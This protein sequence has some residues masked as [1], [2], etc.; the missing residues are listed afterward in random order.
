MSQLVSLLISIILFFE[1]VPLAG[2]PTLTVDAGDINGEV[3]TKATGFLYGIAQDGVPSAAMLNSL[4]ISSVSQKVVDGLQHPSGDIDDIYNQVNDC[5]YVVIYL[6]DAYDTWYYCYDEIMEKRKNGTYDWKEFLYESYFPIL[7]EKITY[8]EQQDYADNLVYCIFNECDNA[9]WF[10]NY[11]DGNVCFDET[12]AANFFEAWKLTYDY[13]KSLAPDAKIGGPGYCDYVTQKMTDFLTFCKANNCVPEVMIYHELS[14]WSIPDWELHV[15]DYRNIEDSLGIDDLPIVVTEYALMEECG[16]PSIMLQYIAA[17]ERT[18]VWGHMAF[19]RLSNNLNDTC[20]DD[21][22]PNSNW[23]LYR[24]YTEMSGQYKLSTSTSALIESTLYDGDDNRHSFDAVASLNLDKDEINIICNGSENK[25]FIKIT[26]LDSTNI[27]KKVTV[28]VECVYFEG[29]TGIVSSPTTIKQYSTTLHGNTLNIGI[30]KTDT[31]AVYFVSVVPYKEGDEDIKNFNLPVRYE[32]EKGKLTGNTYTYD[33][34]YATTGEQNGMVGGI[35]N[36][37][38]GVKLNFRT[39]KDGIYDITLI[40]GKY[41]DS[42]TPAGRDY[43]TAKVIID[44]VETS[45]L[46]ENT[47]KSEFTT[48]KTITSEL[49]K[50]CHT[51]EIYYTDSTF[52][53]DSMLVKLHEEIDT[54]TVLEDSDNGSEFLAVAPYDG[55]YRISTNETNI[56]ISIDSATAEVKNNS[57]VYL[58]RG[59]NEISFDKENINLC[60]TKTDTCAFSTTVTANDITLEGKAELNTDKYG[61]TYIDNIS[62]LGGI[63]KFA[64]TVPDDGYY[65]VTVLYSNNSEGGV[66]SY[67]VDLIERYFTVTVNGESKDIFCRNTYSNFT[68]KTTT[69]NLYLE[70][71]ENEITISNSGNTVFYNL[72]ALA[73]QIAQFT[74]NAVSE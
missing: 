55:Y 26:N 33:S 23:W 3:T 45:V 56:N 22:S 59:L 46:L 21:N 6:Q 4:D 2:A 7:E 39:S 13:V 1:S 10:G 58:R 30:G 29:L 41:N 63:G 74:F 42:G 60:I 43:A 38:D 64:V 61:V 71:G 9:V 17:I 48:S 37:G 57:L 24:K 47:I 19:W 35:E 54:I 51:I 11:V 69:F 36:D 68:Y 40:Y 18:G 44:G 49:E 27:G 52:V 50:G 62:N 5:D 20:A 31:N 34:A 28:T 70:E 32:F 66:H 73:P 25:R 15:E 53:L 8:M 16:D 14:Y 65:R 12:G 67:N 72:E